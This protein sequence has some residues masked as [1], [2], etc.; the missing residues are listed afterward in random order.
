LTTGMDKRPLPEDL[1]IRVE[2]S[3]GSRGRNKSPGSDG[4]MADFYICF[5]DVL[6]P[7]LLALYRSMEEQRCTATTLT[8]GLVSSDC[9]LIVGA[10]VPWTKQDLFFFFYKEHFKTALFL[11]S[12]IL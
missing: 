9:W 2:E 12:R 10:G 8:L 3:I 4:I 6:A 11:N 5:R 1:R 7:V